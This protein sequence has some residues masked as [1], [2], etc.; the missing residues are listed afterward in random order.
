M[1]ST[2]LGERLQGLIQTLGND[3]LIL[4]PNKR[5]AR[6]LQ[7]EFG[8]AQ[9]SAQ[10]EVWPEIACMSA[11]AWF[12]QRWL[13]FSA[14]HSKGDWAK[15]PIDD[16]QALSL[17]RDIINEEDL[18]LFNP[19]AT[20]QVAYSAWKQI[21]AFNCKQEAWSTGIEAF[22]RW[23]KCYEEQLSARNCI[24]PASQ[25]T[26]VLGE[27][28][29]GGITLPNKIALFAFDDVP[30]HVNTLIEIA[31]RKEQEVFDFSWDVQ[32]KAQHR[33]YFDERAE[34]YAAGRWAKEAIEKQREKAKENP[35]IESNRDPKIAIVIPNLNH[36]REEVERIFYEVFEPAYVLPTTTRHAPPFNISA[37]TSLT[38]SPIIDTALRLCKLPLGEV[39][40]DD[41]S[42]L[43]H[44]PYFGKANEIDARSRLVY[45]IKTQYTVLNFKQLKKE[46]GRQ[47]N[48]PEDEKKSNESSIID[49][50]N[51]LHG[52]LHKLTQAQHPKGKCLYP[53]EWVEYFDKQLAVMGWPGERTLNTIEFQH[54]QLWEKS[55]EAFCRYDHLDGE[56]PYNKALNL[57]ELLLQTTT[58]HVQT[59]DSPVQI[60]GIYEAAGMSFDHLWFMHLDNESWPLVAKPNALL[61]IQLQ[62]K[63]Q[64]PLSSAEKE[65]QLAIKL[66]QRFIKS[67][68]E[69]VFSSPCY[70]DQKACQP[71]AILE[72]FG[73]LAASEIQPE[74][75]TDTTVHPYW[76]QAKRQLQLETYCDETF[77]PTN[78]GLISGGSN[79]L[80]DQAACP[81]RAFALHRLGVKEYYPAQQGLSPIQ[82]GNI[83][84]IS[85][86]H[87]WN[88]FLSQDK[89][90]EATQEKIEAVV[91][92]SIEHAFNKIRR[93]SIVPPVFLDIEKPRVHSLIMS[94]LEIEKLRPNFSVEATEARS[95]IALAGLTINFR[96]DRLDSI[97]GNSCVVIDYK[98]QQQ[99]IGAWF[100]ERPD[101]A[102]LPLYAL[103]NQ[104]RCVGLAFAILNKDKVSFVGL[105]EDDEVFSDLKSFEAAKRYDA[106]E[107]M[108]LLLDYWKTN[109]ENL[110]Q[111]FVEGPV[112]VDPKNASSTCRYCQLSSLCRVSTI[113]QNEQLGR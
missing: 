101:E 75:S 29:R 28:E 85:L 71:S 88:E 2:T 108:S 82:K 105:V 65:T 27:V 19:N 78:N 80:K 99:T 4:T 84:H 111:K 95:S 38:D 68:S 44:S 76:E 63:Y 6:F 64:M 56:I 17:W 33:E 5:L 106:P 66:T 41:L 97:A 112:A 18:Q 42:L 12:Q 20:A 37:A 24:D 46:A 51:D 102:Q 60:L 45:D 81:F 1:Q 54:S 69:V 47:L 36:K 89:Y 79:I 109:L 58:F 59:L 23:A 55:K 104:S 50:T 96:L 30:P 94:F 87:I 73:L 93:T 90:L 14:Q 74:A 16:T 25:L 7:S 21:N 86:E 26:L 34:L 43:L 31:K 107:Q 40:I 22:T 52:R 91:D 57:F 48:T 32:S 113:E 10:L 103:A 53:S 92:Q 49:N 15:I 8:K 98:T 3:G 11:A 9:L 70:R 13:D 83:V 77:K 110:A 35:S 72:Q 62:K 100:G 61:P 39:T 67:A